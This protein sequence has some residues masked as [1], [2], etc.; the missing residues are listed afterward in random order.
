MPYNLSLRQIFLFV[1]LIPWTN[2]NQISFRICDITC[3][4]SP[5]F[6][7][8]FKYRWLFFGGAN[9][10]S[11]S[12]HNIEVFEEQIEKD[13]KMLRSYC[14]VLEKALDEEDH[15]Y[16]YLTAS[17]GVDT[18]EAY[19]KWCAKAKKILSGKEEGD[20]WDRK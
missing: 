8:W 12:I 18:Y 10:R 9:D 1:R 3:P 2:L 16:Y 11:V 4:L 13:L 20:I 7:F 5:W 19:L 6:K 15:I 17:F 14:D